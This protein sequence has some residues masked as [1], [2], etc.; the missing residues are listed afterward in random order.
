MRTPFVHVFL[1]AA[2]T[3]PLCLHAQAPASSPATPTPASTKPMEIAKKPQEVLLNMNIQDG[4]LSVDGLL[5]K[6]HLDYK[7]VDAEF[8]Y[9]YVP[10]EGTAVVSRFKTP[11]STEIKDAF[12]GN[13]LRFATG[14]H[15]FKLENSGPMLTRGS[16]TAYVKLD[17]DRE[18]K[19]LGNYPMMGFGTVPQSPYAWPAALPLPHQETAATDSGNSL[20]APPIPDYMLPR[21][22]SVSVSTVPADAPAK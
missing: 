19:T 11:N 4:I 14:G 12:R 2:L 21:R 18:A 17:M 20:K 5:A 7:V 15:D 16:A 9:F 22:I 3:A 6:V 8:F 1:A 10:G 13:V